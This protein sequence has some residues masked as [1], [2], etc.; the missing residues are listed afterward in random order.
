MK[1]F[2]LTMACSAMAISVWGQNVVL[3]FAGASKNQ[4][5]QVVMD[6]IAY[7]SSD[8]SYG[9]TSESI[10]FGTLSA[11]THTLALY[12]A[13]VT[14]TTN[15]AIYT[16]SFQLR[17]GYD[18]TIQL[19]SNGKL[20]YV[21][22]RNG[23]SASSTGAYHAMGAMNAESFNKLA[24]SIRSKWTQTSRSSAVSD[25]IT[26]NTHYFTTEQIAQLLTYIS[27]EPNRLA[28]AK[29]A[30]PK[31]S[32]PANYGKLNALFSSESLQSELDLYLRNTTVNT[33]KGNTGT[34]AYGN[35]APVSDRTFNRLLQAA[36][37]QTTQA[38]KVNVLKPAL[39]STANYFTTAQL[40]QL[41]TPITGEA[42]RLALTKLAYARTT[43]VANFSSLHD[44]FYSQASRT[45]L[46]NFVRYG[47]NTAGALGKYAYREAIDDA[48][49]SR[50][51]L[52]VHF[53]LRQQ[54]IKEEI[55]KAFSGK[56]YFRAD[57]I[58][59]WLT[60]IT[61]ESDRLALAKLAY[62][63]IT[64]PNTFTTLYDLFPAPS[65]KSELEQYIAT[66]RF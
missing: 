38:A 12:P 19:R 64:D 65:S 57:Q 10:D 66:N 15:N 51:D 14:I 9:S 62:L 47:P 7:T 27:S 39:S 59:Q 49:F 36:D 17:Q 28:L 13:E 46:D 20:R 25:A 63:R 22:K 24:Q 30:Y 43:D 2:F 21:E 53:Q 3:Q 45:E 1:Y 42:D 26:S 34:S 4:N 60:L 58:R 31:V 23:N 32:D 44:L 40:R 16:K 55:K 29:Q 6:G 5:Y 56:N 41:L 33:N 50:M 48:D 52:K 11:G 8:P 54:A 37:K 18:M 61:A 35:R